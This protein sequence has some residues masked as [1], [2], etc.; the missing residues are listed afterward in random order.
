MVEILLLLQR[1]ISFSIACHTLLVRKSIISSLG[2][3]HIRD[4][5]LPCQ[6]QILGKLSTQSLFDI[7]LLTGVLLQIVLTVDYQYLDSVLRVIQEYNASVARRFGGFFG[8]CNPKGVLEDPI[9]AFMPELT[10]LLGL[11]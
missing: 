3:Y 8:P 9:L 6:L 1:L 5:C 2:C 10:Y 7:D 4:H 11:L